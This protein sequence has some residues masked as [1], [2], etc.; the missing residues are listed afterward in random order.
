MIDGVCLCGAV[1]WTYD[2]EPESA[3]ACNC[4]ACR[5]YGVLWAYGY[6]GEDVHT[7]GT[8]RAYTRPLGVDQ[9]QLA[10]HF[11]TEC[12]NLAFW[13]G[14]KPNEQG[15]VRIGVNLRLAQP[16]AVA[17]IPIVHFDG[18]KTWSKLPPDGK[19]VADC[20]F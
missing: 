8:T 19:R 9:V 17:H 18:L 1:R 7:F 12:G 5:R 6:V 3:L 16:D 14:L 4:T 15:Q 13:Q 10:F 20:W 11:C 2:H